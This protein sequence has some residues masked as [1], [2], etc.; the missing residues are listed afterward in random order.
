M[1]VGRILVLAAAALLLFSPDLPAQGDKVAIKHAWAPGVYTM[2]TTSTS[3]SDLAFG[4]MTIKNRSSDTMVWELGVVAPNEKGEKKIAAKVVKY[5][6]KE[7][8]DA[9]SAYDS[10]ASAATQDKDQAFVYGPLIGAPVEI[11]LDSDDA[12]VEVS[13]LDRLWIDLTNK[14]TTDEQKGALAQASLEL[15][16]KAVEQSLRRL[17]SIVPKKDVGVGEKWSA[18]IRSDFPLIGEI[19]Q[20]YDCTLKGIQDGPTGKMAVIGIEARYES[21]KPKPG[22]VQG[23]EVT[24]SKLDVVEKSDI[25]VDLASGICAIDDKTIDVTA[26]LDTKDE[27]GKPFQVKTKGTNQIRT[28]IVPVSAKPAP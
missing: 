19:K 26:T 3:Q 23:Y 5:A 18:G 22:K 4:E 14:A 8:G 1:R 13:G 24:V 20:R 6:F 10:E 17:E 28:T 2:T 9:P 15:A 12:V 11:V 7:E 27:K 16:D 21:T 25:T